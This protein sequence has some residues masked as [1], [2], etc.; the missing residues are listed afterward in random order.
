MFI[1]LD[2]IYSRLKV[3]NI[4]LNYLQMSGK[5]AEEKQHVQMLLV[6]PQV[7]IHDLFDGPNPLTEVTHLGLLRHKASTKGDIHHVH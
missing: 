5:H 7:M 1:W 2:V 6:A 3:L 4:Y